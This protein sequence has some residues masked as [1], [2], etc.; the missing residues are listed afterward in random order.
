MIHGARYLYYEL[1]VGFNGHF[2]AVSCLTLG[3]FWAMRLDGF[4]GVVWVLIPVLGGIITGVAL[5]HKANSLMRKEIQDRRTELLRRHA[6][7]RS[8]AGNVD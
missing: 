8:V 5:S 6:D 7:G 1:E 2:L 3:F 4:M